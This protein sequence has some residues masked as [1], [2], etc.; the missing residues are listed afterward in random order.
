MKWRNEEIKIRTPSRVHIG[1]IDLNAEIGRVDGGI[2]LALEEPGIEISARKSDELFVK[3]QHR[4]RALEAA[5]KFMKTYAI[6]GG[7]EITIDTAYQH[8]IGLGLGTQLTLG[9]AYALSKLYKID[10]SA[11]EIAGALGRGGTSGIGVAAFESGGF[12]LDGGHSTK[13]KSEFLPSSKSTAKPA[14]VLARHA[15][16]DWKIALVT[17]RGEEV[18]GQREVDIFKRHCPIPTADVQ[19]LSHLIL[20]KMLPSVVEQDITSFGESVNEIQNIGFKKIELE[21]QN[22]AVKDLLKR[23]QKASFGAGLSSFGPTIYCIVDDAAEL[24]ETVAGEGKIMFT[25]ADNRGAIFL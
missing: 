9:V 24:S 14:P 1:L 21:R 2:G 5:L 13:E 17:P 18:S 6:E 20:M 25:K 23:C 11:R 12:I 19:I 4:E 10:V 7:A 16:P 8:H 22:Q 15:F 3:G